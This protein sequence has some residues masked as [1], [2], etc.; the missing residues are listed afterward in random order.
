MVVTP[1]RYLP[2]ALLR[3]TCRSGGRGS[4]VRQ[5]GGVDSPPWVGD[6]SAIADEIEEFLTGIRRAPDADRVLPTVLFTDFVGSTEQLVRIGDKAWKE[7]LARHDELSRSE[8]ERA[9]GTYMDSTGDRCLRDFRRTSTRPSVATAIGRA[10]HALGIEIRAGCHTGE[11][12]PAGDS[13]RVSPSTSELGLRR[14]PD[15]LRYLSLPR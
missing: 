15:L 12:E 2:G 9:R 14:W 7:L 3:R 13:V 4:E 5:T 11:I 6:S 8:V 1:L 10:I